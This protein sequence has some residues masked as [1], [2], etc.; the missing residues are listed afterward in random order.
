MNVFLTGA[1]GFIGQSLIVNLQYNHSIIRA[2]VRNVH[3]LNASQNL[4]VISCDEFYKKENSNNYLANI[5][6]VIH[7]AARVHL[8]DKD[9]RDTQNVN[10]NLAIKLAK[11]AAKAGVKRFIFISSIKVN[12]EFTREGQAFSEINGSKSK[13]P[14]GRSKYEAEKGLLEIAKTLV[15]RWLLFALL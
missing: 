6:C 15:W 12:G 13:D 4:E 8:I 14:Y 2:L 1:S 3:S 10:V 11:N 9:A 7:L 5:N